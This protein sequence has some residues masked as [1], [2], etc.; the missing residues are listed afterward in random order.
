MAR[1]PFNDVLWHETWNGPDELDDKA[2]HV[3]VH[4]PYVYVAGVTNYISNDPAYATTTGDALVLQYT[5]DGT[6]VDHYIYDQEGYYEE[7]DGLVV[8]EGFIYIS[9]WTR[10]EDDVMDIFVNKLNL[11]L[12]PVWDE[13]TIWSCLPMNFWDEANGQIVVADGKV[14]VGGRCNA[15][16]GQGGGDAVLAIFNASTGAYIDHTP[17]AQP[18]MDQI[19]GLAE[20]P[21]DGTIVAVG[22]TNSFDN[23]VNPFDRRF[24][25]F[26][27]KY[28]LNGDPVWPDVYRLWGED[29]YTERARSV[30]VDEEG[31]IYV[32]GSTVQPGE[33]W[34]DMVV[35]KY[36]ASGELIDHEPWGGDG[37]DVT[38]GAVLDGP[39]L[40]IAGDTTSY[41]TGAIQNAILLNVNAAT[42]DFPEASGMTYW[43]TCGDPVCVGHYDHGVPVCTDQTEGAACSDRSERCDPENTCNSDL[44]CTNRNPR[45]GCRRSRREYKRDI[46]YVT[47]SERSKLLAEVLEIPL[48]TY[49]Y[50]EDA[51]TRPLRLGFIIED[52]EPSLS[53]NSEQNVVDVYAFTSMAVAAIQEQQEQIEA[54]QRE[55]EAL[56]A[57]MSSTRQGR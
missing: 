31:T 24:D 20:S 22:A 32:V 11:D 40:Y 12:D 19:L 7:V 17:W 37:D 8:H 57:V 41:G 13:P 44:L 26:V 54:L 36:S 2:F 27:I 47:E 14:F 5:L 49:H 34:S 6:Y 15:N 45:V 1:T 38:H 33:D 28:D 30:V 42:L 4:E 55:V 46:T 10:T 35:L 43:E 29:R 50:H 25:I 53:V 39:A 9:G 56:R 16:A 21:A 23:P 51:D 3:S 52:V 18:Y 48:V